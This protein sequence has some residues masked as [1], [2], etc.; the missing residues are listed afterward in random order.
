M[1]TAI[2]LLS[3]PDSRG[4]VAKISQFL[5]AH[6]GNIEHADQHID[7]ETNTLFMRIEWAL[8]GFSIPEDQIKAVL[9]P[10]ADEYN[11]NWQLYFSNNIPRVAIFV[12]RH[13]HCL[14]DLLLRHKSGQFNCEIPLII[15]NHP[16][17]CQVAQ[18][19][20]VEFAE[21]PILRENKIAQEEKQIDILDQARIDL[22]VLARY[23]QIFTKSF[24]DQFTNKMINIHHSFLPA[25]VGQAPYRQAYRRGVKLIG[26][27]SHYVTEE[28]DAG[29]IIDQD[30]VR[31]SHRDSLNDLRRKGEDLERMVLSRAVKWHTEH[32]ILVY[33]NKTVV[34]D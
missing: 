24:V 21:F 4:I 31:V 9:K 14:Y 15:S 12:S 7:S 20:N 5:Y 26:A 29:P 11:M 22:I 30:T 16:D 10:L 32:K 23:A 19:F 1:E 8:E 13:L 2:L 3:C 18:N 28:L 34:F 27:T 25:F 17:A 6:N 33:N